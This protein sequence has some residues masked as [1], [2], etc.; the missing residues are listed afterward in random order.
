MAQSH[1]QLMEDYAK[2][3]RFGLR[4]LGWTRLFYHAKSTAVGR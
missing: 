2:K 3:K 4:K 1:A